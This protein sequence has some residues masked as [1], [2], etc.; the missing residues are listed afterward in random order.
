M[1][2]KKFINKQN[3]ATLK[4]VHQP[5]DNNQGATD[6]ICFQKVNQ[7]GAQNDE[8]SELIEKELNKGKF[9]PNLKPRIPQIDPTQEALHLVAGREDLWIHQLAKQKALQ[10]LKEK[11]EQFQDVVMKHYDENGLPLD[12]YDYSQHLAPERPQGEVECVF[13]VPE[14]ERSKV[15]YDIDFKREEL[16]K[17]QQEVYDLL[18][19]EEEEEDE[20]NQDN[21]EELDDDFVANLIQQNKQQSFQQENEEK[22]E[23]IEKVEKVVESPKKQVRFQDQVESDHDED[24][25][26]EEEMEITYDKK[27]MN[28]KSQQQQQQQQKQQQQKQTKQQQSDSDSELEIDSDMEREF[29]RE[30]NA[31]EAPD[32]EDDDQQNKD[33]VN[34]QMLNKVID[35]HLNTMTK[36]QQKKSKNQQKSQDQP[37]ET[38]QQR[39]RRL[40]YLKNTDYNEYLRQKFPNADFSQ[41]HLKKEIPP[42]TPEEDIAL[43]NYLNRESSD[44]ECPDMEPA[45]KYQ[46]TIVT[47]SLHN[48]TMSKMNPDQLNIIKYKSKNQVSNTKEERM[49]QKEEEKNKIKE[50]KLEKEKVKEAVCETL[51]QVVIKKEETPEEKKHRKELVKQLKQAQKEKKK[52]FKEQLQTM[53]KK[54]QKQKLANIQSNQAE[55]ISIVKIA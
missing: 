51:K 21:Q 39:E 24:Y 20:N 10:A 17:E 6:M 37:E 12:G 42:L 16:T 28:K 46:E 48:T 40:E 54:L 4:M 3:A 32:D 50:L 27:Q 26:D 38:E 11:Q 5:G 33:F 19:K 43:Q 45:E 22:V 15:V 29:E 35:D 34:D 49:K 14:E 31:Y 41:F 23:K 30:M 1:G 44:E 8:L 25:E 9:D 7:P 13:V 53:S 36:K 52:A 55:G 47:K 18:M 2:K